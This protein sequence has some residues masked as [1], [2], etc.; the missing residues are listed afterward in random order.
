MARL[1][2]FKFL[3]KFNLPELYAHFEKESLSPK[4]YAFEW[5]L[6]L[7]SKAMNLDFVS[8]IWDILFL[9]GPIIL[10]KTGIG[11]IF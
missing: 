11:K 9:E 10:Y 5:F 4:M 3:L 6:T 2:I 1:E 7:Y 8:R